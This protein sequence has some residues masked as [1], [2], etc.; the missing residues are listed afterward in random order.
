MPSRSGVSL[1]VL[2]LASFVLLAAVG[3]P[4]WKPLLV[5]AALAGG[6]SHTVDR[7]ARRLGGRRGLSAILIA[8]GVVLL[9]IVPLSA[10]GLLVVNEALG[11]IQLGRRILAEKGIEGVMSSLPEQLRGWTDAAVGRWTSQ[12]GGLLSNLPIWS[13]TGWALGVVADALGSVWQFVLNLALMLVALFF[14]LRDGPDLVAWLDDNLTLQPGQLR[15]TLDQLRSVSRSVVGAHFVTGAVQA[16]VATL[17]Y[18]FAHVPSP[19]L[20]GVVTLIASFIP[21]IGTA[22][23][24]LPLAVLLWIIGRGGSALFLVGWT[25]LVTGLID[26]L[27]RPLLVRGGTKLHGAVIFFSLIGGVLAFGPIGILV[28][29][30]AVALFLS[31]T[32]SARR[33]LFV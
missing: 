33:Q 30:L 14:L 25:T 32:A 22:L 5:A 8:C 2:T 24:G 27:V 10:L 7:V 9:I 11:V 18:Y 13:R 3:L 29:P 21:S 6:L 26:N 20:F 4:L 1:L 12:P 23:V 15:R 17:G 28:G 16:A 31:V 19:L